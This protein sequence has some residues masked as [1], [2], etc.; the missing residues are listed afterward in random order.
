MVR[1]LAGPVGLKERA[2]SGWKL[3]GARPELE[4]LSDGYSFG[5]P[6]QK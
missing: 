4:I 5:F 1:S 6:I 3:A 2:I